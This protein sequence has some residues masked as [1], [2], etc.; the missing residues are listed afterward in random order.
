MQAIKDRQKL[1]RLADRSQY[2]WRAVE[3]YLQED[4]EDEGAKKW[5]NAEK[6]MKAKMC[7]KRILDDRGYSDSDLKH[8]RAMPPPPQVFAPPPPPQPLMSARAFGRRGPP[9][10]MPSSY[11]NCLQMGRLKAQCLLGTTRSYTLSNVLLG[12]VDSSKSNKLKGIIMPY[13]SIDC[14]LA[15]ASHSGAHNTPLNKGVCKTRNTELRN[16]GIAE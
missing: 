14:S 16:N 8:T 4:I 15:D 10:R 3:E 7:R 12:S 13:K 5:V 9:P 2:G 11:F 6:S 1:I